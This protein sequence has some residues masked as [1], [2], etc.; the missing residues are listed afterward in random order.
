MGQ[1]EL[2]HTENAKNGN[3]NQTLEA[4]VAA[5]KI[6]QVIKY[7]FFGKFTSRNPI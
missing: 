5:R 3:Q 1:G 7:D 6:I 2:D 4:V